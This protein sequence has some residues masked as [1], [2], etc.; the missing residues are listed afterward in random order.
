MRLPRQKGEPK[1]NGRRFQA[2]QQQLNRDD[3]L[4]KKDREEGWQTVKRRHIGRF[5]PRGDAAQRNIF[6]NNRKGDQRPNTRYT[7]FN[8]NKC[9]RCLSGEHRV[10]QRRESVRCHK[11]LKLGHYSNR[12]T[13]K[14]QPTPQPKPYIPS[15][16]FVHP[17][18]TFAQV[19]SQRKEMNA[20]INEDDLQPFWDERPAKEEVKRNKYLLVFHNEELRDATV[21]ERPYAIPALG[22]Q[23]TLFAW[24]P[25]DGFQYLPPRYEAWVRLLDVPLHMWNNEQ[26]IRLMATLGTIMNIMP[27]GLNAQQ[28]EHIT[29]H[30]TTRHP[31]R[32]KWL[33]IRMGDLSKRIKVQLLVWGAEEA[34]NFRPPPPLTQP[35]QRQQPLRRTPQQQQH[36]RPPSPNIHSYSGESSEDSNAHS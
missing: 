30:L 8:L 36:R 15:R 5:N 7:K 10:A 29:V 16:T 18:T 24:E 28:L 25:T 11:C 1:A 31:R 34:P 32:T 12:C 9:F 20:E 23:F 17:N 2:D 13:I 21:Q 27:Y 4:S 35:R 26:I 3:P 14:L 33:K 22:V 6:H 19:V